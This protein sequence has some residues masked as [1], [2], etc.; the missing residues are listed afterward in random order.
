MARPAH[1]TWLGVTK[2]GRIAV[3]TNYRESSANAVGQRSRGSIVNG[4]LELPPD[5]KAT[6]KDYVEDL[7]A[8]GDAQLAG[9]FSLACGNVKGPLAVVSNRVSAKDG[10]SWI[11]KEKGETVGLSNTTFGD[12]SWAKI[13]NGERMMNEAISTSCSLEESED[14]LVKRLL[15][16]LS[17]DTLPRLHEGGDLESYINLLRES[18]FI[19]IIG[20]KPG[21]NHPCDGNNDDD[22]LCES[23]PNDKIEVVRDGSV[24]GHPYMDGLYGT[25]KQT[26]VLVHESG[27]VR[28]FE[29]TLYN[30]NAEE[31][32]IG[33][34]DRSFDFAVKE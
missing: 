9:G 7:I 28:F 26:I 31:I 13:I 5:S 24:N 18:I 30:D 17:L 19:P 23:D 21:K 16:L 32:P 12:R 15:R 22:Q 11:A 6:A 14:D 25:Q 29:R 8:G 2:Q 3:L 4:F 27:R 1:G 10:I 34:G 33:E 20:E